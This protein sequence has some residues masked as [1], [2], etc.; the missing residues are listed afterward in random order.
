[1]DGSSQTQTMTA[2]TLY[3]VLDDQVIPGVTQPGGDNQLGPRL[4]GPHP[5]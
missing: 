4:G 2:P 3:V 1:M 5:P